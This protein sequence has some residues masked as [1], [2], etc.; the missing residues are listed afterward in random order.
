MAVPELRQLAR[1]IAGQS[2]GNP[3]F[4][5]AIFDDLVERSLVTRSPSG[6]QLQ[7]AVERIGFEVPRTLNQ[8]IETRIQR[9]APIERRLLETASVAGTEF[10]A[11]TAA[12]PPSWMRRGSRT[13]ARICHDGAPSSI[14]PK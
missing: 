4:M 13:P 11:A 9:L 6:W 5:V 14:G 7:V 8:L 3:L 1:V 2:G 12:R 10:S